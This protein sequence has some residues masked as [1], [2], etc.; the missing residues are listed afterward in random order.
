MTE[1]RS[2]ASGK[3]V[4]HECRLWG[5]VHTGLCA[6]LFVL[7]VGSPAAAQPTNELVIGGGFHASFDVGDIIQMPSVPSV[8]VRLVRWTSERWGVSGR[9]MAGLGSVNPDEFGVIERRYPMYFQALLKYRTQESGGGSMHVGIGGGIVAWSE[10]R[11]FGHGDK[12]KGGLHILAVEA[13]RSIPLSDRLN[14]KVGA[15]MVL[16]FHIQPVVLFA[17]RF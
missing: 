14:M 6:G 13:L 17:W 3:G 4:P 15:T 2:K 11:D 16:P 7:L 8:D 5:R 1:I 12:F 10:T 9:M